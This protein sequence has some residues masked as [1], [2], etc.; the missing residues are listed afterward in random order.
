[1]EPTSNLSGLSSAKNGQGKSWTLPSGVTLRSGQRRCFDY[2]LSHPDQASYLFELPT[3][4]GKTYVAA[5]L[6][7]AWRDQRRAKR[8]VV[9]VPNTALQS[10]MV[11]DQALAKACHRLGI[12][13]TGEIMSASDPLLMHRLKTKTNVPEVIVT[14]IQGLASTAGSAGQGGVSSQCVREFC[15]YGEV[16][17]ICDEAHHYGSGNSWG[18]CISAYNPPVIAGLSATPIR[19]DKKATIFGAR[20]A[21]VIVE[22]ASAV[23]EGAIRP[24]NYVKGDFEID[25]EKD[26]EI[27]RISSSDI[28][29]ELAEKGINM[30]EWEVKHNIRYMSKY[31]GPVVRE[32]IMDLRTRNACL[33]DAAP[34]TCH[35][36]IIYCMSF[37]HAKAVAD[38]VNAFAGGLSLVPGEP[39]A[40]IISD[41]IDDFG[42]VRSLSSGHNTKVMDSFNDPDPIHCLPCVI[43][44]NKLSEGYDNPRVSHIVLLDLIG[45]HT[46]EHQQK[47]GRGLRVNPLMPKDHNKLWVYAGSDHPMWQEIDEDGGFAADGDEREKDPDAEPE[48][49]EIKDADRWRVSDVLHTGFTRDELFAKFGGGMTEVQCVEKAISDVKG[50]DMLAQSGIQ[51]DMVGDYLLSLFQ[52]KHIEEQSKMS[53]KELR[54]IWRKWNEEAVKI[55]AK[56]IHKRDHRGP[57]EKSQAG[58]TFKMVNAKL[59]RHF[60]TAVADMEVDELK[61]RYELIQH[62]NNEVHGF[63]EKVLDR[64]GF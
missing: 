16:G 30:S 45:P 60:R 29:E 13:V 21:D 9:V 40:G 23:A 34:K 24:E 64:S 41:G 8:F 25:V 46:P 4:Y 54:S 53:A 19:G 11:D 58:D 17:W 42:S 59:K 32:A 56:N 35:Q 15:K 36:M 43:C 47:K 5:L 48:W 18:Q 22:K 2:V 55:F 3:G 14:T 6:I 57:E 49:V 39:F 37:K 20:S 7:Q 50:A 28:A 31:I 33:G 44:V 52:S 63:P 61:R 51:A 12:H 38:V 10:Q 62:F 1:M 26:G 27:T